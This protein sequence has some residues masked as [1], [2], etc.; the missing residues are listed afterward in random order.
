M[1]LACGLKIDFCSNL[2]EKI[3]HFSEASRN[4]RTPLLEVLR[5]P[6]VKKLLVVV[7]ILGLLCIAT[8]LVGPSLLER[9]QNHTLAPGPYLISPE[10]PQ[11]CIAHSLSPTCTPI[12]CFGDET[13]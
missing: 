10:A 7:V 9:S 4:V 11:R 2:V 6:H 3:A 12:L 1:H 5:W 13:S 8:R